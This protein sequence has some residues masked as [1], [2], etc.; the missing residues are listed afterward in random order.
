MLRNA[1]QT[2]KLPVMFLIA[3]RPEHDINTVFSS[4]SMEGIFLRLYLDDTFHP[5]ED[6]RKY[7]QETFEEIRTTHPFKSGIP[8][9]WP[10]TETVEIIV[11][12]SSCQFIYA[13]TIIRYVQS[14]R[15]Q[16]HHRLDIAMNLR[17]PRGDLP[18][19]QLDILYRMILSS[20][21]DIEPVLYALSIFSLRVSSGQPLNI[22]AFMNLADD[23]E[24]DVL[25]CDLG[26]FVSVET[27]NDG[28]RT[29]RI[30]H[31]SLHDFLLDPM[32]SKE[33]FIN[34]DKYR[35]RL[36]ADVIDYVAPAPQDDSSNCVLLDSRA[37]C[38]LDFFDQNI[39]LCEISTELID[40]VSS[41]PLVQ[42][43]EMLKV[44]EKDEGCLHIMTFIYVYLFPFVSR[45]ITVRLIYFSSG[46]ENI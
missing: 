15:H 33:Y 22:P 45:M 35:S 11:Q 36:L 28:Y 31:A 30:L 43:F 39:A 34:I 14:I 13:A 42:L 24:L 27:F 32:R 21:E 41:F 20:V 1:I 37:E 9:S 25:F 12:K 16:P 19:A 44:R 5:D 10:T 6:I 2:H 4:H 17:P 29:L 8:K 38:I 26:A 3:S 40:R 23:E 7:L 46:F 18:F